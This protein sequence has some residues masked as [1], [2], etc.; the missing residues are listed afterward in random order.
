MKHVTISSVYNFESGYNVL[1]KGLLDNLPKNNYSIRPR[2][3]S[4]VTSDFQRYFE[5]VVYRKEDC[6]LLLLPPCNQIDSVHPLFNIVPAKNTIFFTM[7]ESSRFTDIF[8]DKSNTMQAMIVPNKWNKQSLE[9]QGCNVPIHIVPLFI[10]DKVFNYQEPIVQNKFIFGTANDDPRKRVNETI[11]CFIK[12]FPK[13]KDVVLKVKLS[14]NSI[15]N[16]FTDDRIKIITDS[17]S[18][19]QLVDF[20]ASLNVFV[21]GVSSEGWGLHQH[22]SMACGRPVIAACYAGLAEF[23][24]EENSFCLKYNEVPSTDYWETPGGKWS[25]YDEDHMIETM[26]Y[27]YNNSSSVFQKGIIASENVSRFNVANFISDISSVINI[28]T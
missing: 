16:K 23:M 7:W 4:K 10:D 9:L 17:Y 28:Y 21:S 15:I 26:R 24:T 12:A 2:S 6:N 18:Q 19:R 11:K 20:Y 3:Y 13:E 22:E 25:K 5:N 8:I 14:K 27:C 1:L